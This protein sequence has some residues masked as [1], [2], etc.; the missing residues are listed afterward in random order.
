MNR[1]IDRSLAIALL[2]LSLSSIGASA[3]AQSAAEYRQL[4]LRYREQGRFDEAI[5]SLK[6]AAA[7]E[8]D[9]PTGLVMLGWTLHLAE[10]EQQAASVLQQALT[11]EPAHVPA[12]NALGIVY[13]VN[14]D[15]VAAAITHAWAAWLAPENEIAYYN[16]SLAL[17]GMQQHEWAIAAAKRAVQLE[18]NNPHPRVALAIAHWNNEDLEQAKQAYQQA[19]ELD[20]RYRSDAHLPRLERAGFSSKQI[21]QTAVVLQ[22]VLSP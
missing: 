11:V 9:N 2:L 19:M 12:L 21:E 10:Q 3:G 1:V 18:P 6:Q 15:L 4:G 7:L 22:A 14:N 17:Q 5:D 13:L 8:P 20:A 16:L